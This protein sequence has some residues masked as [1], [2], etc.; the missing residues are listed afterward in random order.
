MNMLIDV[1]SVRDYMLLN[2]VAST[3]QYT[4]QTISSNIRTAT[5]T[6]ERACN[7]YF[8]PR[9]FTA[10]NPWKWTTMLAPIVPLPG[11]RSTSVITWSNSIVIPDQSCW[12]LPDAMQT[13]V[14]TSI[15][16]RPLRTDLNGAPW[17]LADPQWYDKA[18]DSPF[19]P[20]NYGGG[21]AYTSM[22]N[23][24]TIVGEA[25]YDPTLAPGTYGC[26]PDDVSGAVKVMAS[27]ITMRPASVLTNVA[28]TPAGAQQPY[29]SFP[30]EVQTFI[31][32][33]SLDGHMMVSVG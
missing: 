25:G 19:Y 3:S 5:G 13:G 32:D 6:L 15:Q 9:S 2:P 4:D 28:T 18:L 27:W 12:L 16:F 1:Q 33:W 24:L 14:F 8:A 10:Q 30:P 29:S 21:V 31:R 17:Y 11:F 22:P 7:R 20:G 26:V 23:D